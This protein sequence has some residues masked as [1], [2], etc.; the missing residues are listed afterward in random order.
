MGN[1]TSGTVTLSP[2]AGALGAVTASLPAN[3]GTLAELNLA[4]TWSALQTFG[5]NISIGGV[6]VTGA[7]GTGKNV[8]DTSPALTTPN[9]GTPS[10]VTLTNGTGLPISSGVSGLA[11]GMASYLAANTTFTIAATGCTP[12]AH[13]GGA[14]AGSI[15]LAAGPC[16]SIIVTMNG[17]TG[18]TASNG[19]HCNVGDKTTQNAGTWVPSWGESASSTTTA[20]I[21]IP[22]AAGATDV[23]TFACSPY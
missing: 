8:F 12:S 4:Q 9:L 6:T 10:A 23:V 18:Y 15:T 17:A 19:F 3:T 13:A 11:T 1:A 22:A 5:T 2:V 14:F 20:T 7:T 21:P 16:T